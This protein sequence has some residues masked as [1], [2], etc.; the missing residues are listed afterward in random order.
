MDDCSSSGQ[1]LCLIEAAEREDQIITIDPSAMHVVFF[2]Y[3]TSGFREV[4]GGRWRSPRL[5]RA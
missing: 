5:G 2:P 4:R 3:D 1:V